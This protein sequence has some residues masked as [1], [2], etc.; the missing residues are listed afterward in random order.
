MGATLFI[1]GTL[2]F[3]IVHIAIANYIPNMH[4]WSDPPGKFQQARKEIGVNIPYIL[5]IIF[6]VFGFILLILNEVK[7]IV[8]FLIGKNQS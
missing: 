7:L 2:L 8:N 3:G 4:V 1:A 6:M 5:S